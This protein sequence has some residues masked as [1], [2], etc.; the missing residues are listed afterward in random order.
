[1][2]NSLVLIAVAAGALAAGAAA[3]QTMVPPPPSPP[4]AP[5]MP[6]RGGGGAGMGGLMA[7]DTNGDGIIT[8]AEA[9]AAADARFDRLDT[10]HDGVLSPEEMQAGMPMTRGN[11]GGGGGGAGGGQGMAAM[12]PVT[13]TQYHDRA[14]RPFDR[15]DTNHDGKLDQAELSAYRDMMRERRMERRGAGDMTPPPGPPM[16]PPPPPRQ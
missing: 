1:M 14:L 5:S 16:P 11:A 3:A 7:A 8:R 9:V 13:R 10:N 2:R 15:I 4:M 12:G 6:M